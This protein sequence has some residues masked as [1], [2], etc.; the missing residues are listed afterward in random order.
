[1]LVSHPG[2]ADT[3]ATVAAVRKLQQEKH[4]LC[5]GHLIGTLDNILDA[6]TADQSNRKSPAEGSVSD[7]KQESIYAYSLDMHCLLNTEMVQVIW[8]LQIHRADCTDATFSRGFAYP[9]NHYAYILNCLAQ[10]P[11]HPLHLL[12]LTQLCICSPLGLPTN[13]CLGIERRAWK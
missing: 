3:P 5:R 11:G 7:W 12:W 8:L 10:L 2:C 4:T 6:R 9:V 13:K 1:M